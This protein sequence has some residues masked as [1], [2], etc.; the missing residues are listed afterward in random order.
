MDVVNY[1]G[2]YSRR[3]SVGHIIKEDIV[4]M[5]VVAWW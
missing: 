4:E 1:R 5:G 2:C 3:L